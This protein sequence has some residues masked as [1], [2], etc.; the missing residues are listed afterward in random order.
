MKSTCGYLNFVFNNEKLFSSLRGGFW[1]D[2]GGVVDIPINQFSKEH[3]SLNLG[4]QNPRANQSS[5]NN[6][7]L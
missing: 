4:L 7:Q 6:N 3:N 5:S 2:K 1:H